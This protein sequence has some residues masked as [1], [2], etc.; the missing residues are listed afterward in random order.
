MKNLLST[1]KQKTAIFLLA[2][3]GIAYL[4]AFTMSTA[5]DDD[6]EIAKEVRLADPSDWA[7]YKDWHKITKEPNTG[8]PTGFLDKKHGGNG[9]F[10]DVYVN[11][12]GKDAY[13]AKKFPLPEGTVIVKEAFK[14]K[15]AYDAQ[16]KPELTIMVKLSASEGSADSGN[17]QWVMGASGKQTGIGMDTKWGKFCASCHAFGAGA[18]YTFMSTFGN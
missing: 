16:K 11:A 14:N 7:D 1:L 9:A 3:A 15:K 12:A 17:W 8:D 6:S 18:D 5:K 13:L 10:R 4:S 2:I